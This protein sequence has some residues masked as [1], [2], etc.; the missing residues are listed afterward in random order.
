MLRRNYLVLLLLLFCS[1]ATRPAVIEPQAVHG[2]VI[3]TLQGGVNVSL[4]SPAGKMSGNGV[5]IYKRPEIFRLTILAPF[6]QAV[7]DIIVNDGRVLCLADSRKKGWQGALADLP[8]WL[9]ARIWPLLRWVVEPPHPAGAALERSFIRPD[10]S[11]EKLFYDS[12]GYVQKKS[13]EAGD[14]VTYGDYRVVDGIAVPMLI[15]MATVDGN[16][17]KLAFDEPEV[18]RPVDDAVLA[19]DLTGYEILPIAEF[20]GF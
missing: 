13:N 1:C 15:E 20:K 17:L 8:P 14:L 5:L 19:P 12:A 9:G 16:R 18:N 10:G 2:V 7:F 6:G 4:Q 3:D 11:V